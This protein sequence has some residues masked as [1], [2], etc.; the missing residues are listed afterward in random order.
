MLWYDIFYASLGRKTYTVIAG[1]YISYLGVI[2]FLNFMYFL[3]FRDICSTERKT[4]TLQLGYA[5]E[6]NNST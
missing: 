5:L 2:Y 3:M 1:S 6:S 4:S